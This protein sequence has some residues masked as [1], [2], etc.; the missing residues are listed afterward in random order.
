[1][2]TFGPIAQ[3]LLEEGC[4][5]AQIAA[6]VAALEQ[7]KEREREERL[8]RLREGARMRQQRCR[9]RAA[10]RH[11]VTVSDPFP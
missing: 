4:S 8:A 5:G 3:A 11:A 6:A 1:V 10:P 7:A 2:A 9:E